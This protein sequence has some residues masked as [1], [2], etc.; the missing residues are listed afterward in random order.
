VL[1]G[2]ANYLFFQVPGCT[3][4]RE[5]CLDYGICIRHCHNYRNLGQDYYRVA[6]RKQEEN[7]QLIDVLCQVLERKE[8]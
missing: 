8:Q 6:V 7:Q 3:S 4:L 1:K 5:R 2:E